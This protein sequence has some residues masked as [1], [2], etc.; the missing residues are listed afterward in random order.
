MLKVN[1]S[2]VQANSTSQ[3]PHPSDNQLQI[4]AKAPKTLKNTLQKNNS[5]QK[6]HKEEKIKNNQ[7]RKPMKSS[8]LITWILISLKVALKF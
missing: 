4:C 1:N 3:D 7:N 5:N 6:D 2:Y 8:I